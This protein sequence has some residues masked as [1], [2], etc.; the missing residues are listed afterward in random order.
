VVLI[1]K[2]ETLSLPAHHRER[3]TERQVLAKVPLRP[4]CA[5]WDIRL[6]PEEFEGDGRV[7]QDEQAF[8][9]FAEPVEV[10]CCWHRIKS[11]LSLIGTII[12]QSG[13]SSYRT[14]C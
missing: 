12:P 3:L 7:T 6:R 5:R 4:E 13:D 8:Q 2:N 9:F 14:K 1:Q 11:P 10:F